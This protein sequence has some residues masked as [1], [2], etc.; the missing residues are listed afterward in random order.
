[1]ILRGQIDLVCI[2]V[3]GG[4][5]L[6]FIVRYP[7]A[8]LTLLL[9]I[10]TRF[11]S[12]IKVDALP[13]LQVATSLRINSQDI[14]TMVLLARSLHALVRRRERPLFLGPLLL[15]FTIMVISFLFGIASG[16]GSFE[17]A[18]RV[19]R[20]IA[21][22]GIYFIIVATVNSRQRLE[23]FIKTLYVIA[24]VGLTLQFIETA[25]SGYFILNPDWDTFFEGGV[26]YY[27]PVGGSRIPYIWNRVQFYLYIT[28]F[29]SLGCLLFARRWRR[30]HLLFASVAFLGFVL[31]LI[32]SWY[33]FI[34]VGI[35]AMLLLSGRRRWPRLIKYGV[36]LSLLLL[37]WI[38]IENIFSIQGTFDR[39]FISNWVLRLETLLNFQEE[40]SFIGRVDMWRVQ[41]TYFQQSP[42]FG[43]GPGIQALE[44]MN[45]DTGVVN[46][47]IVFGIVGLLGVIVLIVAIF[48]RAYRLLRQVTSSREQ[49]YVLGLI[50]AMAGITFGYAFN[51]D[52]FTLIPILPVLVM[53][54]LDR[55]NALYIRT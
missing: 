23:I 48:G 9:L 10:D 52:A 25:R 4:A 34:G 13:Y 55:I 40:A 16:T 22:Y 30:W 41:L 44:G 42:L 46:T 32:R 12:F 17:M 21:R 33:I 2:L 14:L 6:I 36:V 19:F 54:I 20:I 8:G 51:F 50:G 47:L 24:V 7:M 29:L 11:F 37:L 15:L 28:F 49:A 53:G 35:A 45:T 39:I 31:M 43:L 1:M 38:A 3:V 5:A 27:I 26:P 18:G